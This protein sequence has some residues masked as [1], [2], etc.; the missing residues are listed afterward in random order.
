MHDGGDF[1]VTVTVT[2]YPTPFAADQYAII[3]P[4]VLRNILIALACMIVVAIAL[5]PSLTC[6]CLIVLAIVSIDVGKCTVQHGLSP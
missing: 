5:I 4:T 2:L 6:A 3:T 1:R